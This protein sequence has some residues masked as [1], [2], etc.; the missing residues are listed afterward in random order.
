MSEA[1]ALE[2]KCC[3][4]WLPSMMQAGQRRMQTDVAGLEPLHCPHI[5][6]ANYLFVRYTQ[7]DI[8]PSPL[9]V[10]EW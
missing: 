1:G 2:Q 4:T 7:H 5:A 10:E 6:L 8:M 9:D 3:L